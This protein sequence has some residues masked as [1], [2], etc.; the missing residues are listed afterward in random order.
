MGTMWRRGRAKRNR[1][2]EKPREVDS[3]DGQILE[4]GRCVAG[5]DHLRFLAFADG[6]GLAKLL[7]FGEDGVAK[8]EKAL[9]RLIERGVRCLFG[10]RH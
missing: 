10:R 6:P 5:E 7:E 1:D 3:G 2:D 4:N 9:D 8:T